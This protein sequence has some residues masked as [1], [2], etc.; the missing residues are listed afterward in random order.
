MKYGDLIRFDPIEDVIQL[1]NANKEGVAQKL[2]GAYVISDEMAERL[3]RLVIP[4]LQFDHPFDNKG[5]LVV[6]NYGTGKSHLL[7]VISSVAENASLA[8]NIRHSD[9]RAAASQI[10]GKFKVV[11][12]EIGASSMPLREMLTAELEEHLEKLGVEY[13]FP[14]ANTIAGHKGAFEDMMAK[15]GE[16]FPER[17]LLLVVDELLD[18]LK[19]RKDQEIILDLNF[20]REIGEVCKDL[21][22]RFIAGVQEAIFDS[23]GFAFVADSIRRVKDRFEQ[24]LIARGDVKFVVAERLL[25]KTA[26]Q[27]AAIREHLTPFAKYYGN[28]NERMDEFV[29]LFPVHPDYIDTFERITVAEKREVLKTLSLS[30]KSMLDMD[31]PQ[32]SPGLL[33]FDGYWKTLSNNASFRSVPEIRQVIECSGVLEGRVE[34]AVRKHYKP[35]AVRLIH[36]L[37]IHRLTVGDIYTPIGISAAELRDRLFLFDPLFAE[38]CGD[39]PEK[40]LE[41]F[42]D[43]VLREIH[44][45]VNGQFISLNQENRQYYLDLKKTDDF[46]ALIDNRAERFTVAQLDRYYY[47][48]LTR[49]MEC[50]DVTYATGYKIW[51]HEIPWHERKAARSGYLFF[52][53]PNERSTAVPRRD[54]YLYFIQPNDPPRFKDEK[55]PDEVFFRLKGIDEDFLNSLRKYAA[56]LDLASTS[57]GNAKSVYESK[58]DLFLKNLVQWMQKRM[59]D[60]FDVTYQGVT[61]SM[62]AWGKGKSV[63]ELAGLSLN[64]TINFR[65]LINTIAGI[66]LSPNFE[67]QAPDHPSFS[68]MITGDNRKQ[69]AQD[70]LRILAG[71]SPTK[72]AT[73]VLDALELLD[74]KRVDTAKSRYA[75]IVLDALAAKGQGQVLNR[76]EIIHEEQGV[77]YLAPGTARLEPEWVAVVLAALVYSGDIV[78]SIPGDKFDATSVQRLVAAGV[79]EIARFKHLEKPKEWN[80]PALKELFQLLGITPGMVHFLAEGKEEPVREMQQAVEKVVTRIVM[81]SKSMREGLYF[82]ETELLS[83]SPL[84]ARADELDEAKAFFESL[85]AYTTP[86]KLKNFRYGA[87]DVAAR[88][89]AMKILD[90][91]DALTA[92]VA[93]H[94]PTASWLAGAEKAMPSAHPWVDRTKIVRR[95]LLEALRETKASELPKLSRDIGPSLRKLKSDYIAEYIAMHTKARLGANDDKRKARLTGDQRLLTLQ[96]LTVIDL[97]PRQQLLDFQNGLAEMK[98]CFALTEREL[99]SSPVCP[100]CA[101]RPSVEAAKLGGTQMIEQMDKRLDAMLQEWTTT[102]LGNLQDP[103]TRRNLELLKKE[104]R[105]AIQ[106]FID[107]RELPSPLDND[108]VHTLKEALSGLLKVSV[109]PRELQSVLQSGGAVAP[110]ELKKRFEDYIDELVK[111]KDQSKVRLVVER[112]E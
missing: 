15:F 86:G 8:E 40:D 2:V 70:A 32:E 45:A 106:R 38:T 16:A 78:L 44:K 92:F 65:D 87:P 30:M 58:A 43:T 54:F 35:M 72:Q 81:A 7:S 55:L 110:Q 74:G 27:Q 107:S 9:V 109:N 100:H 6:G 5:L 25:K 34:S 103:M 18:Y 56:A 42:V 31:V 77:E 61:K 11:R 112:A 80:F 26:E 90:E 24:V 88:A 29:R 17:G 68:V 71:Q 75:R 21:R 33:A 105:N 96:K 89:Q 101:F 49:V 99:A 19:T 48:A 95:D 53:T 108:F 93:E 46:D 60:A 64:D 41:T 79:D 63:R 57:S 39:E 12:T 73:A 94:A 97:M 52:G 50:R 91:L 83:N 13:A 22:F 84:A 14:E 69:A 36:A 59:H 10:A 67:N 23:P 3:V 28:L 111:G 47:D 85:Q 98:S 66:C 62:P 37:S 102:I 20:L 104:E 4:Q 76:N 1:R 51:Q 82:W